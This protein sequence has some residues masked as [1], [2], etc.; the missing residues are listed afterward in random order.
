MKQHPN[1]NPA[2][3]LNGTPAP[4]YGES[5]HEDDFVIPDDF[6][7]PFDKVVASTEVKAFGYGKALFTI[8]DSG[9]LYLNLD[10]PPQLNRDGEPMPPEH[11]PE[12]DHFDHLLAE[13]LCVVVERDED[14]LFRIDKPNN[15]TPE[16][17]KDYLEHYWIY[18]K[19]RYKMTDEF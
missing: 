12:A 17:L 16:R 2:D 6:D 15:G 7:E 9:R 13:F 11:F 18:R 1:T 3:G 4:L 14:N 5:A 10:L 19:D 8:H